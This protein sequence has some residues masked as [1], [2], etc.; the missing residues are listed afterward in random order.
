MRSKQ[1]QH[2]RAL[3]EFSSTLSLLS[4]EQQHIVQDSPTVFPTLTS[5]GS[6]DWNYMF[7]NQQ[8]MQRT[9]T[10]CV[11]NSYKTVGTDTVCQFNHQLPSFV[12]SRSIVSSGSKGGSPV[13]CRDP[14]AR[15]T[16]SGH[17]TVSS[18]YL[19]ST[20]SESG[21]QPP[22]DLHH[23]QF[24]SAAAKRRSSSNSSTSQFS[25]EHPLSDDCIISLE[26]ESTSALLWPNQSVESEVET[27][28]SLGNC[29][30]IGCSAF[31]QRKVLLDPCSTV[32]GD[33][34]S[35][36]IDTTLHL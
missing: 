26:E 34:F 21:M 30:K 36:E 3:Y 11:R 23:K 17:S 15:R 28:L 35:G 1:L 12:Q 20:E 27:A 32:S 8:P 5:N 14:R 13:F 2:Q 33:T 31:T 25:F 10:D 4:V 6:P 16:S 18:G 9:S 7:S 22:E 19:Q 29:Y 24:I